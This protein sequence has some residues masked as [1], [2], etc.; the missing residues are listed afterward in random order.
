MSDDFLSGPRHTE[1]R[2]FG[3][4]GTGKTTY[5][6]RQIERAAEKYGSDKIMV[7]SYTKT[8]AHELNRRNLP[9]PKEA[10]GTIHAHCYRALGRP[11]IAELHAK[12]WNEKHPHY[13]I[14]DGN[15]PNDELSCDATF[16]T[17]GDR[18]LQ[19]WNLARSRMEE[20]KTKFTEE[21]RKFIKAWETWKLNEELIDFTDMIRITLQM[22]DPPPG[23][24]EISFFDEIQDASRLMM[25]LIRQWTKYQQ[26]VLLS[27]D[28]DQNLFS[29]A[30]G[31][32]DAFLSPPLPDSQ[33]HV[34][35]Q[36]WRIPRAI[37]EISQRWIKQ[38][39]YRQIKNFRPRDVQGEVMGIHSTYRNPEQAVWLAE[40]YIKE[41]KRVMF[42]AS[43]SYMLKG[44]ISDLR[45][46]AVPFWNPYRQSRGD[47]NPLGTFKGGN[48][49]RIPTRSRLLAFLNTDLTIEGRPIWTLENLILWIDMLSS[50]GI[51][52][53]GAKER[54]HSIASGE[55]PYYGSLLELY[56][57]TFEPNAL[58]RAMDRNIPWFIEQTKKDKK[59]AVAFPAKIV[60]KYG[61]K[62]LEEKPKCTVGTVHSVKGGESDVV[63]LWPDISNIAQHEM[64]RTLEGREAVIRMFYVGMTRARETLLLGQPSTGNHVCLN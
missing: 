9:I 64:E 7:A 21:T 11:E 45:K 56:Q 39:A 59:N 14:S 30:G 36:S 13:C 60:Q 8:A 5:L 41:G 61:L 47:W 17:D 12:E 49:G 37:Q 46:H 51:L 27:G 15:N 26:T 33:V 54:L 19:E 44:L 31:C 62:A 43:C 3:P 2:I 18:M 63:I 50:K 6:S 1:H 22:K 34:L 40:Q 23:N 28:D 48:K 42:L 53:R 58:Q 55:T 35:S 52:V 16:N 4:P 20:F 32:A 24:P 25:A 29:F 38:I 10:I 57:S